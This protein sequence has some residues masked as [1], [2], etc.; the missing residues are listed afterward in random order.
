VC[1]CVLA[2][3]RVGGRVVHGGRQQ[4]F[5]RSYELGCV[6]RCLISLQERTHTGERGVDD[7]HGVHW[8]GGCVQQ[9]AVKHFCTCL[10]I[11]FHLQLRD[12]SLSCTKRWNFAAPLS[13]TCVCACWT[14]PAFSCAGCTAA[15]LG[16]VWVWCQH[17]V[18]D[19][20]G[21]S[22]G[23]THH[24]ALRAPSNSSSRERPGRRLH[25]QMQQQ[26]QQQ[27]GVAMD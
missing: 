18:R 16:R 25:K 4:A 2:G 15:P 26:Q 20:S 7:T 3:R 19:Q 6:C 22:P 21:L 10:T 14:C 17:A 23:T 27:E 5:M 11:P 8:R 12:S 1:C 9:K 24:S 13:P